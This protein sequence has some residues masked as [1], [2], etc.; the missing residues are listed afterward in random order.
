MTVRLTPARVLAAAGA[1]VAFGLAVP[2]HAAPRTADLAVSFTTP[3]HPNTHET[4]TLSFTVI[5]LGPSTATAA[6]LAVTTRLSAYASEPYG[7]ACKETTTAAGHAW[8]CPL[9][10]L[11]PSASTVVRLVA[12]PEVE[13]QETV[14]ASVTSQTH[15]PNADNDSVT[16]TFDVSYDVLP[17]ACQTR[18]TGCS[19]YFTLTAPRTVRLHLAPSAAFSGELTARIVAFTAEEVARASGIYSAGGAVSGGDDVVVTLPAGS[20]TVSVASTVPTVA[21]G[22]KHICVAWT[23]SCYTSVLPHPTLPS[24]VPATNG[25]VGVVVSAA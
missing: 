4:T 25:P 14:T 20:W 23:T 16:A 2:A 13:R 11:A 22:G 18:E 12:S 8:S 9:G 24:A 7:L 5:N 15:D 21:L 19:T 1:A 6:T 17:A 3:N 10:D